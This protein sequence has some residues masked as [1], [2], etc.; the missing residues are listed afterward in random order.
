MA[1][2]FLAPVYILVN[3]YIVRWIFKWM[4]ACNYLFQSTWFQ[5][6]FAGI[7]IFLASSLLT[8]FLIKKPRR[9]H[10]FLKNTGNY[11]LGIFMYILM[12]VGIVDLC[13]LILKYL[14]HASWIE[15]K[16]AFVITGCI[17]SLFII[18]ISA[19]GIIHTWKLKITSYH[20]SV[21]KKVSNT[22]GIKIVLLADMHFGQNVSHLHAK[23]MVKKINA[24]KPDLVCI[25]GDVFDNDY[26]SIGYP[27]K[28][29][30]YLRRI[31]SVYGTYACWGNHDLNEPILAGFTF[32]G[33]KKDLLDDRME[34][35]LKDAGIHLLEDEAV[36]VDDKFY[37]V[38]RNDAERSKKLNFR[39]L[40]PAQLTQN[41]NQSKP[42]IF[43]DHQP[44]ELQEIAD[45]GAD[46][47]LCG[48]THNGQ[49]FPGNLTI[50]L[51]WKNACGYLKK[52]RLHN[53]VTSGSGVWG[54]NM[55]I[56]T[57][58]EICLIQVDFASKINS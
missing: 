55:R 10:T 45:A 11:F 58:N 19:Y 43:I 54:P 50:H 44:K 2:L 9:L 22:S 1:A 29:V 17:C 18:T 26:D 15:S 27:E 38:G 14:F 40:T 6:I 7:Y 49:M 48:H 39:R 24:L 42:I 37:I 28:V 47:D 8:G 34:H 12:T 5:I 53:I 13:R 25:A 32:K 56:G 16:M 30:K 57:D 21:N 3:V 35:L 46:L 31:Q 20:V 52:D 33:G 4:G 41:L 36:L 51:F 23:Q